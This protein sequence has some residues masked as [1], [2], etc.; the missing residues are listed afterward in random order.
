M[1][2][3]VFQLFTITLL[4]SNIGLININTSVGYRGVKANGAKLLYCQLY[5]HSILNLMVATETGEKYRM[6]KVYNQ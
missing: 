1:T 6:K 3:G 2:V 4:I 5:F